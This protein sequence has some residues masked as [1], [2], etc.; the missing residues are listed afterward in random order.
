[1]KMF[2]PV[3][4]TPQKSKKTEDTGQPDAGPA[5]DQETLGQ[6]KQQVE[7]LRRQLDA[8]TQDDRKG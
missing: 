1:M 5:M 7:L 6:L 2:S 4:E 8:L 3:A